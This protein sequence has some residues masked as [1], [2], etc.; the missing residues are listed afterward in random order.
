MFYI[1]AVIESKLN[2][3]ANSSHNCYYFAIIPLR[4]LL[5]L[6]KGTSKASKYLFG[7]FSDTLST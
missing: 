5:S 3:Y 6:F 7:V 1:I 4:K 2:K